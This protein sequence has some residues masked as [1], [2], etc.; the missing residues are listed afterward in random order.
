[1]SQPIASIN[2]PRI[3]TCPHGLPMGACP[4]CNGMGGGGSSKPAENVRKP[5]EMTWSQCFAMGQMMKQAEARADARI[6]SPLHNALLAEQ[7]QKNINT[8]I[9]NVQQSLSVL[10]NSLPTPLA[11]AVNALNQAII[12]PL[13]NVLAQIPKLVQAL[14]N[15]LQNIRNVLAH[16]SEK[17]TAFFGEMKNFVNKKISDFVK[18]ATKKVFK[19]F[20]LSIVDEEEDK[21]LKDKDFLQAS[22]TKAD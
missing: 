3:G 2:Q 6:Q 1:M 5:G 15:G 18:S 10:Q 14:Q 22:S 21:D 20:S 4:I 12:T 11:N 13:L 16:V 7:L 19:F 8:Y 9:N 17:L